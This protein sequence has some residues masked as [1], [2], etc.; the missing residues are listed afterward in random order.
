[1]A[2]KGK[3]Q[4]IRLLDVFAIGPLMIYA[5]HK[6]QDLSPLIK[7]SLMLTGVATILYNGHNYLK[8]RKEEKQESDTLKRIA[9]TDEDMD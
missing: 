4:E 9:E 5:G 7:N 8:V 6:S 3:A 1:M 2:F